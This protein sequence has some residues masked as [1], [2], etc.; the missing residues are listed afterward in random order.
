M[1]GKGAERHASADLGTGMVVLG[2]MFAIMSAL[3][4]YH[5][6]LPSVWSLCN[7]SEPRSSLHEDEKR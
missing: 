4:K 3:Q 5:L 7:S 1:D 6:N 2:A